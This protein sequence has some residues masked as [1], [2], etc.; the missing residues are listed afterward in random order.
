MYH[1]LPL[2][3]LRPLFRN[4][5]PFVLLD[6]ARPDRR[7][8]NSFV[9]AEP[10]HILSAAT[11]GEMGPLLREI[12]R[13]AQDS[14]LAGYLAYEAAG[15]L[16]A[17][18]APLARPQPAAAGP[19]GWFGV[20]AEPYIFDHRTGRWN[21]EL[22]AACREQP[23]P[24][25]PAGRVCLSAAPAISEAVYRRAV[26]AIRR[27][28]AAGDT[29]QIN[30]TYDV[31]VQSEL[32]AF[33]LYRS[34][35]ANQPAPYCAF[36]ATGSG[37]VASFSPEL[38]FR[39]TGRRIAVQ[40]M[41]GTARRGRF[42]AEDRAIRQALAHDEKNRSE[43]LMIVD[44]MRNDL[45]KI[46]TPGSVAVPRLFA[47]ESWPTLHQM[48]STVTGCLQ[49]AITYERIFSSLF[50]CGSVTGAPKIRSMEIIRGLE[51]GVRGVYCGAVGYCGPRGDAVFSVPIRTLQS[52]P[53]R[54]RWRYRVGSGVVWD[55]QAAEEWRECA[56]KCDFLTRLRSDFEIVETLLW[57]RR[58]VYQREHLLRLK[59]AARYFSYPVDAA[60]LTSLL[61]RIEHD[62]RQAPPHKVRILLDQHGGVRWDRAVLD[63]AGPAG[64][65]PVLFSARPVD[66]HNPFLFHKTTY[67]PWYDAAAAEIRAGRCFDVIHANARGE[68]TEGSRSNLFV[69]KGSLL[70]TPA[71]G[72]G[73]LPGV[74]RDRLLR[75]GNCREAV[76]TLTD[77]QTADAVY[78]GNSVRG[79]TRVSPVWPEPA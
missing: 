68:L 16:D 48:T 46:C 12:D 78:C 22:P 61:R 58:L 74:L 11:A 23:V 33:E 8:R 64:P 1:E 52:T 72:C 54:G 2:H 15:G 71:I 60:A 20:F 6:S 3:F 13:H 59:R 77:L 76:L 32:E 9:F 28:I 42:L 18:F 35:R 21:R 40:P 30:F 24:E 65:P 55:S 50:P 53:R 63:D 57:N 62:L 38:F 36:L 56:V 39:K 75:R 43:N 26:A 7:N 25:P 4:R 19:L 27:F 69:R 5:H 73:L 51:T 44:L 34:L 67:R 31:G 45:G 37:C 14:W 17:A 41:K 49:P 47:V 10:R 66:E 70:Y 29:Y 79:L